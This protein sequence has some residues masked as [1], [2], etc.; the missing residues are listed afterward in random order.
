MEGG[1]RYAECSRSIRLD[2]FFD[3]LPQVV[4]WQSSISRRRYYAYVARAKL[5]ITVKITSK[6]GMR[7]T[8]RKFQGKLFCRRTKKKQKKGTFRCHGESDRFS[9]AFRER[10]SVIQRFAGIN[11][12]RDNNLRSFGNRCF[13]PCH[14]R[15]IR[16][17]RDRSLVRNARQTSRFVNRA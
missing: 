16:N 8:R 13:V 17:G 6:R 3:K 1:D 5:A 4:F 14:L 9:G 7:D 10:T 11:H 15:K 12:L 2:F